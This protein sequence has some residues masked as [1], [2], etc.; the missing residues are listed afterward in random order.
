MDKK[1]LVYYFKVIYF[2][3]EDYYYE[4]IHDADLPENPEASALCDRSNLGYINLEG[5]WDAIFLRLKER[6]VANKG[7]QFSGVSL[8]KRE[9]RDDDIRPHNSLLHGGKPHES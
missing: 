8:A 1:W 4:L 3:G 9:W 5:A 7:F 6:M 2:T